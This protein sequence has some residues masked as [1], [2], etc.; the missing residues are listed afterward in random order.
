MNVL[1][2]V[3]IDGDHLANRQLTSSLHSVSL[4]MYFTFYL[5]LKMYSNSSISY[6]DVA[7]NLKSSNV[8]M[9]MRSFS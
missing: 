1:W 9:I 4:L 7:A 2:L 3:V 5:L 6:V 8:L